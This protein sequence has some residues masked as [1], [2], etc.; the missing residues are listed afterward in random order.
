MQ[1]GKGVLDILPNRDRAWLEDG[2]GVEIITCA[3]PVL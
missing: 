3:R 1:F 2:P